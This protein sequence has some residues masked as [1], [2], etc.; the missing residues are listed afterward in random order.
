MLRDNRIRYVQ[1][2]GTG[3]PMNGVILQ[4]TDPSASIQDFLSQIQ[5][6]IQH[7]NSILPK[8]SHLVPELIIVAPPAHPF[9]T[10]DK[11]TVRA[12]DTLE[13]FLGDIEDCYATLADG[14]LATTWEFDGSASSEHD[15]KT[16]LRG[17]VEKVL[18][19]D[20][21]DEGDLF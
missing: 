6:M 17:M 2:F 11:G 18:G 10:T 13:K 3:W 19:H 15:V 9:A 12:K 5:P 1:V 8:Y 14:R 16:F 20:I 21:P 7:V 4:P